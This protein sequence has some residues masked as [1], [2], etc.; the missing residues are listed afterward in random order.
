MGLYPVN[1]DDAGDHSAAP[2]CP[3]ISKLRGG[4]VSDRPRLGHQVLDLGHPFLKIQVL[5]FPR[6]I[7]TE[8]IGFLWLSDWGK[9]LSTFVS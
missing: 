3:R 5:P 6:T 9:P 4:S 2:L 1:G 8:T 7:Q